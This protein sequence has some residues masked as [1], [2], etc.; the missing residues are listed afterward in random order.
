MRLFVVCFVAVCCCCCACVS[1]L[2]VWFLA[3]MVVNNGAH[4]VCVCFCA[5][6]LATSDDVCLLTCCFVK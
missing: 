3:L 4:K 2:F 5:P 1:F 6:P